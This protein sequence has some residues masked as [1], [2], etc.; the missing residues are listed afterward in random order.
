MIIVTRKA[1][2]PAS[3][4]YESESQATSSP[5]YVP[6]S[7]LRI[8]S[9]RSSQSEGASNGGVDFEH[10][11]GI[12]VS[13]EGD[14]G[15]N[16]GRIWEVRGCTAKPRQAAVWFKILKIVSCLIEWDAA[17]LFYHHYWGK[18]HNP[19]TPTGVT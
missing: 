17:A 11:E 6:Y 18:R 1:A 10:A 3:R 2:S 16:K 15:G 8:E 14:D 5:P 13:S 9:E 12:R 19:F 7:G 4:L